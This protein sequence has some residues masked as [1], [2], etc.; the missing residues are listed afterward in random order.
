M[1]KTIHITDLSLEQIQLKQEQRN[2]SKWLPGYHISPPFG[3]LNDPNG[4]YYENGT[5]QLYFQWYP[6]GPTHGL[7]HWLHLSSKNLRSFE[8]NGLGI[9]P[10]KDYDLGGAFSGSAVEIAG[11]RKIIYTSNNLENGIIMQRQLLA[12]IED[13][14]VVNKR[15]LIENDNYM[16]HQFRDPTTYKNG[17]S[18]YIIVG[19][20]TLDGTP[21]IAHYQYAGDKVI[22][23]GILHAKVEMICQMIECP[24]I[25]DFQAEKLFISSP[26]GI[27]RD[28]KN[29]QNHFNVVY[30]TFDKINYEE[31]SLVNESSLHELD[32]GH[33]FYAPQIFE[34]ENQKIL[35][36]WAGCGKSKYPEQEDG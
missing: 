1:L 15:L 14:Q 9:K 24:Q 2:Q 11:Q 28:G 20:Q 35:I 13:N 27:E 22:D 4:L 25:I 6:G 36:A 34:A 17:D 3:L 23:L 19:A 29:Y 5:Y 31:G 26:Q 7:K 30:S 21:G 8:F 32:Y 10:G 16:P 12:E 33:D 18:T